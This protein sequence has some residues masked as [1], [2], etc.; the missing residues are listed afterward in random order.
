MT[1]QC[2]RTK[3]EGL[4]IENALLEILFDHLAYGLAFAES[5]EDKDGNIIVL[6]EHRKEA[7]E[8]FYLTFNNKFGLKYITEEGMGWYDSPDKSF[9]YPE[10][11]KDAASAFINGTTGRWYCTV[12]GKYGVAAKLLASKYNVSEKLMEKWLLVRCPKLWTAPKNTS[13]F[14]PIKKI[15]MRYWYMI[16]Y[17]PYV[18]YKFWSLKK[19]KQTNDVESTMH[20]SKS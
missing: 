7:K 3:K 6:S 19:R 2:I 17:M 20:Q 16:I 5:S 13:W 14:F 11:P 8:Q 10:H 15:I 1:C 4:K 18:E 9:L 12:C